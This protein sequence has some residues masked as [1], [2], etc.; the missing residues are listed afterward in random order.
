MSSQT[1]NS[2]DASFRTHSPNVAA[3]LMFHTVIYDL[4]TLSFQ[5]STN[6][7]WAHH[8]ARSNGKLGVPSGTI[9]VWTSDQS[10]VQLQRIL[11][12]TAPITTLKMFSISE[13]LLLDG[14]TIWSIH[15]WYRLVRTILP[16]SAFDHRGV[17]VSDCQTSQIISNART[18]ITSSQFFITTSD[19]YRW[20]CDHFQSHLVIHQSRF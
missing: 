15:L 3:P 2:N 19:Q 20:S 10:G 7:C 9:D 14:N 5:N 1:Q 4:L 6:F 17:D 18:T 8:G 11:V 16:I 13:T 12:S